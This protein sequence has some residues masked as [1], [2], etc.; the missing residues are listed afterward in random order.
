MP[1]IIDANGIQ[2]ATQ[3]ELVLQYV[4]DMQAIYGPDINLDPDSPDGQMMMIYIQSALDVEDLIVQT[5]NSF[6]PDL[7]IGN[8]LDQRVAINGI[9]RQA[10]TYSVTNITV[11]TSQALNIFGL[12]QDIQDVFTVSDNEGNRWLLQTTQN[13]ANAGTFVY[14]FRAEDP[15]QVYTIPNTIN[16]PVTVVLGVTSVNNPTTYTTLGINEES[17]YELRIRRQQS[18][19]MSSQGY[20]AGLYAALENITG[21]TGVKIVE[22]NTDATD[23]NG[24]PSHS[25]WVIVE[26]VADPEEIAMAIYQHRNAGCGMFGDVMFLVTQIDQTEFP[27]Y[28]DYVS[29][30]EIFAKFTATSLDGVNPPNL[31]A[32]LDQLPTLFN[33]GIDQQ[34]NINSLAELIRSIDP[35]TLVT[36]SGFALTYSGNYYATLSPTERSNKFVLPEENIVAI[37]MILLPALAQVPVSTSKQFTG[38]GGYGVMVYSISSN[39]SGGSIDV[40]TGLYTAGATPGTDVIRVD[41]VVMGVPSGFYAQSTVTVV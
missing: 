27:I 17:D 9:Q 13:I 5:F 15:G 16:I 20:L 28:W 33:P 12:D 39:Q 2:I 38:F 31:E 30:E 1:N 6:D 35:N 34:V 10:G 3:E 23:S 21:I 22:N 7:A 25:I 32:I 36:D 14:S 37:P 41:S 26:G 19:Q 18:V 29:T 8:T 4:A 11:V 24:V 40:N